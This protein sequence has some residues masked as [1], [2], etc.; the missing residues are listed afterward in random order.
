MRIAR[1]K[2]GFNK[3]LL[4]EKVAKRLQTSQ[5]MVILDLKEMMAAQRCPEVREASKLDIREVVEVHVKG[6][7]G[8]YLTK[9]GRRFLRQYYKTILN[10]ESS[11]CLVAI[12]ERKKIC[13]L[14]FGFKEAESVYR[15]LRKENYHSS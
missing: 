2:K 14:A 3:S 7:P 15:R 12:D 4:L 13:G 9:M 10:C 8:F 6:F 5:T 11:I 1:E